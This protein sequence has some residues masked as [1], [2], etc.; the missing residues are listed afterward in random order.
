M[1]DFF[2]D[3]DAFGH[4]RHNVTPNDAVRFIRMASGGLPTSRILWN[5]ILGPG[6]SSFE[7]N[8]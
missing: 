8:Y 1:R 2:S 7:V 6:I 3:H 5:P 4:S